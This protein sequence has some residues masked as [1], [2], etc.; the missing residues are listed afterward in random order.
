MKFP[1]FSFFFSGHNVRTPSFT[2]AFPD[3]LWEG[4]NGQEFL[5][6]YDKL[7]QL[8][9]FPINCFADEKPITPSRSIGTGCYRYR[10]NEGQKGLRFKERLNSHF[11]AG[12]ICQTGKNPVCHIQFFV[13]SLLNINWFAHFC[14]Y[15]P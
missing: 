10:S 4:G 11:H 7:S 6:L 12:M 15:Y 9:V 1:F 8:F 3:E 13:Y 2:I 14:Y 5:T